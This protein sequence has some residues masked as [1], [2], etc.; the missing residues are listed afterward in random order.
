MRIV[1]GNVTY[2]TRGK[3][4]YR[5]HEGYDWAS[6][7]PPP[8]LTREGVVTCAFVRKSRN[9]APCGPVGTGKA[10]MLVATGTAACPMGMRARCFTTAELAAELSQAKR[11]GSL[12]RTT[13]SLDGTGLLP[14][15][16][17]GY[18]PVDGGGARPLFQA[19]DASCEGRGLAIAT[20]VDFSRWGSVLADGQMAAAIIDRVAHHGRPVVF[21]G[22][23][24]R[25]KHAPTRASWP[26]C[27]GREFP[28]ARVGSSLR[29][30]GELTV[31]R[32]NDDEPFEEKMARLTDE[33][34]KCFEKSNRLQVEIKKNL[35]AI[36]YGC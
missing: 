36:R 35:E 25:L 8:T 34:S 18:V 22:E 15:D 10:R 3:S 29:D 32:D 33:L 20:N 2:L 17:F 9:L 19:I 16:E 6:A 13:R 5:L 24:H 14:I 4:R 23:S 7:R 21:G 1:D 11:E 26:Q 28:T 12:Q 31:D 27:E 30:S